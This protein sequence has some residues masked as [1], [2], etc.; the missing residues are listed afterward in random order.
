MLH[1]VVSLRW[2]CI[3]QSPK[4]KSW[5][6]LDSFQ[7]GV[8]ATGK[9]LDGGPDSLHSGL[10]IILSWLVKSPDRMCMRVCALVW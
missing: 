2:S 6:R 4:V 1:V 9:V 7:G 8:E 5:L 3:Q 10:L